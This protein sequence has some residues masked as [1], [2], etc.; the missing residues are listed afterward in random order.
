MGG[1]G[2]SGEGWVSGG[3]AAAAAAASFSL[4]NAQEHSEACRCMPRHPNRDSE[5]Y[6]E[7]ADHANHH[8]CS[9]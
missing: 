5:P 9:L 3:R 7:E 4:A 2:D 1:G 6:N 8:D